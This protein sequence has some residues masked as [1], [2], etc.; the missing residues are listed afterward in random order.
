MAT[1]YY[2]DAYN[3][4]VMPDSNVP[5]GVVLSQF[6]TFV[7]VTGNHGAG[8]TFY[9]LRI[10]KNAVLLDVD[11]QFPA[12]GGTGTVSI[13]TSAGATSVV[14]AASV[15]GAGRISLCGGFQ[16]TTLVSSALISTIGL[17]Y[18]FTA[19]DYFYLTFANNYLAAD[20]VLRFAIKYYMDCG[21]DMAYDPG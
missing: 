4:N 1:A 6:T 12:I 13:G 7:G 15:V 17:G 10:P 3:D 20:A 8:D 14:N 18:K 9:M 19:A 11:L 16:G 2:T 5:A 21:I